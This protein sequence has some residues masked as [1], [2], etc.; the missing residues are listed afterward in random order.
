ML[1]KGDPGDDILMKNYC[2]FFFRTI[3]LKPTINSDKN[4]NIKEKEY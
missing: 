4:E 2:M 1:V 3:W